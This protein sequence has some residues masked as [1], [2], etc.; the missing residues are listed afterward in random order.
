MFVGIFFV[1]LYNF[2]AYL[3][4]TMGNSLAALLFLAASAVLN[5]VL[6]IWFVMGLSMGV[7]GAGKTGTGSVLDRLSET[8]WLQAGRQRSLPGGAVSAH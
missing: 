4:R 6:D 2:S 7:A 5:I 8:M 1:F 3:L